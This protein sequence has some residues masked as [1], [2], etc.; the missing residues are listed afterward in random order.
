MLKGTIADGVELCEKSILSYSN[1]RNWLPYGFVFTGSQHHLYGITP[2]A[3]THTAHLAIWHDRRRLP[4]PDDRFSPG[5][6]PQKRFM[7]SRRP[8][9]A[10]LKLM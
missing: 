7:H 8:Q 10:S 6:T 4:E 3:E 9:K 5:C 1:Y 2:V